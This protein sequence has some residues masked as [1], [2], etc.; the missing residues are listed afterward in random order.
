MSPSDRH[1]KNDLTVTFFSNFLLHH[2]TP[3]CEA[4]V[5]RIGDGYRFVA[6]EPVPQDRL[7]MGYMNLEDAP[8]AVNAYKDESSYNEA[9]RLGYE[10]DV[11][12]IG[13]APDDFIEKRLA[14]NKLTFRY[15]ERYFKK[16]RWRV[17]PLAWKLHY[18][19]DIRYRNKELRM[20]CASAYTAPDCRFIFSYPNKTYKWGYFPMITQLPYER[21]R[22][23]KSEDNTVR[24][25]WVSRFIK[26]K[27]PEEIIR[28]ASLLKKDKLDFRI[29]MLGIGELRERYEQIVTEENLSDVITFTG[30]FSPSEVLEHMQ[31]SDI[32]LFTS[33]KNEGWGAVMNESMSSACAVVACREIGS[34]P[35]LIE[36]GVNG[37]I[38]D[39]HGKNSLYKYVKM[40]IE[41]KDLRE[42]LQKNAYNTMKDVWNAESATD[43][44]LHLIDCIQ[45]G[46]ETGYTSGPCSRD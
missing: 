2:Q 40:L 24:I 31:K 10:S 1:M 7:E 38:Y 9:M 16:L 36:D 13:S 39:K 32:F 19:K 18:K 46:T 26:L 27:H 28:L 11:V 42:R 41:D 12:I 25:I 44:L 43:R 4:M 14:D 45:K 29:E 8:Y 35:Y 3:F 22:A 6:T 21:L 5:K 15:S 37:F 33:D 30:P 23:V 20:L 34:V 17:H